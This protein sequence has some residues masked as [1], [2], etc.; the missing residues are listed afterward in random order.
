MF[1]THTYG[2]GS[3]V[4]NSFHEAYVGRPAGPTPAPD[5]VPRWSLLGF[6]YTERHEVSLRMRSQTLAVPHW[7]VLVA[8]ALLP[9]LRVTALSDRRRRRRLGLCPACGYDLRAT[10]GRCPE[11]GAARGR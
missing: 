3:P 4:S 7:G 10:P 9:V 5:A 11:C 8:F 6:E 2:P 1:M